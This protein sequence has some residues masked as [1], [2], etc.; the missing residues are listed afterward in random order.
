MDMQITIYPKNFLLTGSNEEPSLPRHDYSARL[1]YVT[2]VITG[3]KTQFYKMFKDAAKTQLG[4]EEVYSWN[5]SKLTSKTIN[6][7]FEDGTIG[8]QVTE[9]YS[10]DEATGNQHTASSQTI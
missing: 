10:T 2:E 5:G 9:S 7:Y 8:K 3:G 4:Y 1:P 6:Y